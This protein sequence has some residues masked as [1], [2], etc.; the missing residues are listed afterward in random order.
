MSI[1]FNTGTEEEKKDLKGNFDPIPDNTY[2]VVILEVKEGKSSKG[3]EKATLT[4]VVVDGPYKNLRIWHN[5][6]FVDSMQW[7]IRQFLRSLGQEVRSN[8]VIKLEPQSW[9]GKLIDVKI[10]T[11][12]KFKSDGVMENQVDEFIE[13]SVLTPSPVKMDEAPKVDLEQPPF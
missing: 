6:T 9:S 12:L 11:G 1:E 8:T 10:K 13:A 4:L 5:L 3:N 7:M 2:K